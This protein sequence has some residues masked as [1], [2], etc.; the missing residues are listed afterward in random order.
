M[1]G[2]LS[3]CPRPELQL[4]RSLLLEPWSLSLPQ[5]CG[6]SLGPERTRRLRH[7]VSGRRATPRLAAAPAMAWLSR[8]TWQSALG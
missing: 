7:L 1:E 5:L 8:A 2:A 6:R 3:A 4:L